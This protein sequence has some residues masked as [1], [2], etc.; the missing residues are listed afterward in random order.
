MSLKMN[1]TSVLLLAGLLA[2]PTYA[3]DCTLDGTTTASFCLQPGATRSQMYAARQAV[4]GT[5]LWQSAGFYAIDGTTGYLEWNGHD[6][7]QTCWDAFANIIEQ[8][9]LGNNGWHYH[10]GW[11][12]YNGLRFFMQDCSAEGI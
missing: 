10:S 9:K 4:C 6:S 5:N 7:Q 2:S 12:D 3:A 8:C 11:Y 1:L